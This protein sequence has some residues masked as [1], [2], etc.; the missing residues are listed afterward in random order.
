MFWAD[1]EFPAEGG[2]KLRADG[3][4]TIQWGAAAEGAAA[5]EGLL[6]GSANIKAPAGNY[7]LYVNLNNPDEMTWELNAA[8]YGTGGA[9]AGNYR[10]YVNLNNPDEMTWE[11]NAADYGTGGGEEPDPDPDPEP[12]PDYA[13]AVY[14]N[15]ADSGTDWVD[16]PM[17]TRSAMFG[18]EN[19][20]I[21][22]GGEFLFLS[23]DTGNVIRTHFF[24]G[25]RKSFRL[26]LSSLFR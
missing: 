16:T 7:R 11:L 12:E 25:G 15:T 6:D 4:W 17:T 18:V 10:L 20:A 23:D 9:P 13:W 5:T 2:F 21:P 3:A 8:D 14:G 1:V 26:V 24:S 22:A 19:V